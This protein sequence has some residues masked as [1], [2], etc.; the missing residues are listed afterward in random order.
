MLSGASWLVTV[1]TDQA[2]LSP[3]EAIS[4]VE[5]GRRPEKVAS[6]PLL[7]RNFCRNPAMIKITI[8][9]GVISPRV[10]ITA[11]GMPAISKPT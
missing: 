1:K 2:T 8:M 3:A 11:P 10:A 7:W 5:A 6:T 9:D 4:A